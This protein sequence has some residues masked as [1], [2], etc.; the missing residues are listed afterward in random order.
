MMKPICIFSYNSRGF[1]SIKQD[2]LKTLVLSAGTD[3]IICNQENFILKSNEYLVRKCLDSH[4][5]FFKPA[6]KESFEGRPKNGMFVAV[7][8]Y[9]KEIVTDVSQPSERLQSLIFKFENCFC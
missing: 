1:N 3:A 8:Q 9:L 2:F 7:P 6:Q 5:I 4:H